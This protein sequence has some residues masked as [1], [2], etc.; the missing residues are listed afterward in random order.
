MFE[1]QETKA[2]IRSINPRAENHGDEH[3]LACDIGLEF[4]LSNKKL[5]LLSPALLGAMYKRD[6]EPEENTQEALELEAD[7]LPHLRFP[8]LGILSWKYEGAGYTFHLIQDK[9]NGDEIT[10][11]PDCKINNFKIECEEGGTIKLQVRV[12]GN[13]SEETIGELCR[14][15]REETLVSLLP[16]EKGEDMQEDLDAE[17]D[18]DPAAELLE[19]D[20]ERPDDEAMY[21]VAVE[22]V[23][24]SGNT[25]INNLQKAMAI[26]F[27]RAARL[28]E[29]MENDGI[30]TSM[31]EN[32]VRVVVQEEVVEA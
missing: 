24:D 3:A 9:L 2:L 15:I 18:P 7:M 21:I 11:L 28:I 29:R 16:P 13:P 10:E 8:S 22:H 4:K 1:I 6:N 32:G 25:S 20:E 31:S 26:G 12:Q 14:F 5:A 30:I 27:N 19:D 23:R 17:T